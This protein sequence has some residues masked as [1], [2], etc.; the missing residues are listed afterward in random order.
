MVAQK[1]EGE[2]THLGVAADHEIESF[3]NDLWADYKTRQGIE[4]AL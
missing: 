3:R 1:L 2:A 4:P